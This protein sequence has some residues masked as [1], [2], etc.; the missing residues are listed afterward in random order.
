MKALCT[1]LASVLVLALATP[2]SSQIVTLGLKGGATFAS[3]SDPD[4]AFEDVGGRTGSVFGA[5]I[6]LGGRPIGLRGEVLLVQKGFDAREAG[7]DY[8]YKVDY[9]EI[10]VLLVARLSSGPIAPS[11]Y[12]GVAAGFERSCTV[13]VSGSQASASGDCDAPS[14]ELERETMDAGAVFGAELA[15]GLGGIQLVADGR[16]TVGL[17]TL[18]ASDDPDSVKNRAFMLM[19]GLGIPVG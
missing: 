17:T 1:T 19:F 15:F 13:S 7:D 4:G 9:V 5:S 2:A 6:Q 16:Y 11:L 12:G 8:A 3:V 10:P 14:L 18:D